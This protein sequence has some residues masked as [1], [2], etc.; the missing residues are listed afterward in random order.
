MGSLRDASEL[1]YWQV[2]VQED[3]RTDECPDFLRDANDKD[4]GIL[5]TPDSQ[6]QQD[7]WEVAKKKVEDNTIHLFQRMPSDLR[8]Y[9]AFTWK[10]KQDYGTI[11]NYILTERLHW[12]EPVTPR[13]KPFDY[14]DDL[15]ILWND[16]PYGIDP[17]IV[18]LVVWTKF[19]LEE[20]PATGGLTD[21]SRAAIEAYVRKT[22][23]GVPRDRVSDALIRGERA[24]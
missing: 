20:D 8:R 24:S 5:A 22:F 9:K 16:W 18:H 10:L 15:K 23:A 13:G 7:S 12:A 11:L 21:E 3:Q 6:Y 19:D 2:N 17:Q 1:P 4:R 14:E